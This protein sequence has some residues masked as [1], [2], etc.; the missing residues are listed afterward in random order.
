MIIVLLVCVWTLLISVI[1]VRAAEEREW[2]IFWIAVLLLVA[3]LLVVIA[4]Q[5]MQRA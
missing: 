1:G 4:A 3:T 2:R 5:V